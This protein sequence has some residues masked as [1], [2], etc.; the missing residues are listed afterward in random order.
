MLELRVQDDG[1]GPPPANSS[2]GHG[3]GLANTRARL[4]Q[5]Y[6]DA[7]QLTLDNGENGGAVA[8]M[9]FPYHAASG[10]PQTEVMEVHAFDD[11][12]R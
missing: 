1:P 12:D 8:T 7:G 5:L 10:I 4:Q 6:G 2:Q 9:I 3:I 11:A